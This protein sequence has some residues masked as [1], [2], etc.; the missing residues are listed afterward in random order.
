M[1]GYGVLLAVLPL[2]FL[3]LS[4]NR[5][6]FAMSNYSIDLQKL[7]PIKREDVTE[8][9]ESINF[10][11][12]YD[13]ELRTNLSTANEI[14]F[15]DPVPEGDRPILRPKSQSQKQ[16]D[17]SKFLI[18]IQDTNKIVF[19]IGRNPELEKSFF[20]NI[21]LVAESDHGSIPTA[22]KDVGDTTTKDI[23]YGHKITDTEMALRQIHGIP[24]IDKQGN[25]IPLT[26]NQKNTIF[27]KDMEM[28]L[29]EARRAGWDSKLKTIG[30]SW[31][32]LD[33]QY[34]LPL[35]SLAYNLGGTNAGKQFTKV[36]TAAKEKNLNN[37][38]KE[39]RRKAG[40]KNTKGMDNRVV[41]ELQY[42]GLI[43]NSNSVKSFLP[44]ASI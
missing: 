30:T 4:D 32:Q 37:F 15:S 9:E 39:L 22:T 31:E 8:G 6:A 18:G 35:M 36:L 43:K 21:A 23:A 33:S 38:A 44:L 34:K 13:N 3:N 5:G 16:F 12:E 42:S 10:Y 14:A 2:L 40:G 26:Q 28:H 41:R 17:K 19:D 7:K 25:F 20:A 1:L 29:M 11:P 27:N 24:F